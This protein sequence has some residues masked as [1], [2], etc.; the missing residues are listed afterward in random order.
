MKSDVTIFGHAEDIRSISRSKDMLNRD[1]DLGRLVSTIDTEACAAGWTT[2]TRW[3]SER[4]VDP[5]GRR[6]AECFGSVGEPHLLSLDKA[7]WCEIDFDAMLG[8][9]RSERKVWVSESGMA[10]LAC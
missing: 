10:P 9:W 8:H 7:I 1:T 4:K 3:R 5:A 2:R 6:F